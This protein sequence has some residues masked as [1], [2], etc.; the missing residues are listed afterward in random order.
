[1]MLAGLGPAM[2]APRLV[3]LEQFGLPSYSPQTTGQPAYAPQQTGYMPQQT[4]YMPQATGYTPQTAPSYMAQATGTGYIPQYTGQA[5]R[6]LAWQ[7]AIGLH[8]C[9]HAKAHP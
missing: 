3:G 1:M 6:V 2:P 8:A 5:I 4:G 9:V 7:M